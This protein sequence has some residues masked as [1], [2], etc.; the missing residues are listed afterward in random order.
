MCRNNGH[1]KSDYKRQ[2]IKLAFHG[3]SETNKFL[4]HLYKSPVKVTRI[5]WGVVE[6]YCGD[7]H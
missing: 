4:N 6:T 5:I 7:D 3:N 1:L 2:P